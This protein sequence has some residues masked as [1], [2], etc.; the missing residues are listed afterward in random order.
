MKKVT[1]QILA[2]LLLVVLAGCS[3]SDE[4]GGGGGSTTKSY[5]LAEG[6]TVRNMTA[7][8]Y[9]KMTG[10]IE[11]QQ[12]SSRASYAYDY[13][14]SLANGGYTQYSSSQIIIST[15][16]SKQTNNS[17]GTI[18][19]GTSSDYYVKSGGIDYMVM[20]Q[21]N[22]DLF[23]AVNQLNGVPNEAQKIVNDGSYSRTY[24]LD[25][26]SSYS[27]FTC[28]S[29]TTIAN[30]TATYTLIGTETVSTS[31]GNFESYKIRTTL[32]QTSINTN[33]FSNFNG[34]SIAWYHP[35]LGTVK[36][37][38]TMSSTDYS[39]TLVQEF[40][41][42]LSATNISKYSRNQSGLGL[43]SPLSIFKMMKPIQ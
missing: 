33:V 8:D 24:T 12:G 22:D 14:Q 21:G 25:A 30:V 10:T 28:V 40:E 19:Q 31:I 34:S 16:T 27:F 35:A 37:T 13:E 26:C 1:N 38:G 23:Y 43:W 36:Q 39:P 42:T 4:G 2:F 17:T 32:N 6:G 15:T 20:E 9:A 7:G 41:V 29:P 5:S 11:A 18:T 3:P